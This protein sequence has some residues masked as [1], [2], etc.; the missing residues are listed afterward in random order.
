MAART[1]GVGVGAVKIIIISRA[2]DIGLV[3]D[4][5]DQSFHGT[6]IGAVIHQN[7][8]KAELQRNALAVI[9]LVECSAKSLVG[10][11]LELR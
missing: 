5:R 4:F 1:I 6:P 9:L 10:T 7:E 8:V 3:A 2:F 11:V